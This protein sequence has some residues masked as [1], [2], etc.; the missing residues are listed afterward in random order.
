[1]QLQA[2]LLQFRFINSLTDLELG[3]IIKKVISYD[4]L[5]GLPWGIL[6]V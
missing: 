6:A 3:R 5:R 4:S 2:E 1:L